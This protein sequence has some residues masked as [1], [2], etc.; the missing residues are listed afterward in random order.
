MEKVYEDIGERTF[1]FAVKVIKLISGLPFNTA[2][3]VLGN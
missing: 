2:T 1:K 3:R